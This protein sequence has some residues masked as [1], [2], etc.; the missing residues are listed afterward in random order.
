MSESTGTTPTSSQPISVRL[1]YRYPNGSMVS[2]SARAVARKG[3]SVTVVVKEFFDTGITLA[4]HAPFLEG[5]TNFRVISVERVQD[6]PGYFQT[7]LRPADAVPVGSGTGT[8]TLGRSSEETPKKEPLKPLP[9]TIME[10]ARPLADRLTAEPPIRFSDALRG[11]PA[12][13]R[14]TALVVAVAAALHCLDDKKIV[15]A[16]TVLARARK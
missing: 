11:I 12:E 9:A 7:L 14:P 6:R 3:D 10:A 2:Y 13:L 8:G 16:P 1:A 15:D 4:V 5:L